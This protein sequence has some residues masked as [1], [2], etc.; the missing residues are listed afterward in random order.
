MNPYAALAAIAALP[1]DQPANSLLA[2]QEMALRVKMDLETVA[3]QGKE[4]AVPAI[5]LQGDLVVTAVVSG[6][7][8]KILVL[9]L[10]APIQPNEKASEGECS[11]ATPVLAINVPNIQSLD[12]VEHWILG[13]KKRYA[14]A[15]GPM[16]AT[17][18][19]GTDSEGKPCTLWRTGPGGTE[20]A[21]RV[22]NDSV[23]PKP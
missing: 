1:T 17:M 22:V 16:V 13:I 8:T 10:P 4:T 2:A 9:R 21:M 20:H 3:Y 14:Q 12:A 5:S 19:V 7:H 23:E 11:A 18:E 6:T 15:N